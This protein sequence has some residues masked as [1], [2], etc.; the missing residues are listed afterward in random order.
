M[1]YFQNSL[2][3]HSKIWVSY[4]TTHAWA[5]L[6]IVCLVLVKSDLEEDMGVFLVFW[7]GIEVFCCAATRNF[8][9]SFSFG[10][11]VFA[12]N[13]R[14]APDSEGDIPNDTIEV[15]GNVDDDMWVPKIPARRQEL[16]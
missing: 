3:S 7:T 15:G 12:I 4:F 8:S 16:E 5:W 11:T 13:D 14:A 2:L 10:F 1:H 9:C 6:K